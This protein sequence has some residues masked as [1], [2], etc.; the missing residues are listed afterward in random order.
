MIALPIRQT[1]QP[2][3]QDG[4]APVPQRDGE[5]EEPIEIADPTEAVF[6]PPIGAGVGLLERQI[7]PRVT[8]G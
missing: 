4:I 7:C 6:A 1:E 3:L 8:G 2:F 5:V